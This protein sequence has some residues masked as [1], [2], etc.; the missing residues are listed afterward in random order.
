[1]TNPLII[2]LR[3]LLDKASSFEPKKRTLTAVFALY[4]ILLSAVSAFHEPWF[5]EAEAWQIAKCSSLYD[6]FFTVPHSEGHPPLWHLLLAPFAKAGM[7]YEFSL[8][9]VNIIFISA[10]VW[11]LMFRT[12]LPGLMRLLVPFTYFFF[13][14]YGVVARPYS[15]MTLAVMLCAVFYG[16]K[17]QKP[18]RMVLALAL[19]CLSSAYGLAMAAGICV[20]WLIE[21]WNGKNVLVFIKDFVKTKAFFSLL[22]LLVFAVLILSEVFP[23]KNATAVSGMTN[24]KST[25]QTLLYTLFILPFDATVGSVLTADRLLFSPKMLAYAPLSAIAVT[26]L[27]LF[28]KKHRQRR[29]LFIPLVFMPILFAAIIFYAHYAGIITVL[30]IFWLNVCFDNSDIGEPPASLGKYDEILHYVFAASGCV[31]IFV[32]I[33]WTVLSA[34]ADIKYNYSPCREIAAYIKEN[35]LENGNIMSSWDTY[36]S[37]DG[38]RYNFNFS[39]EATVVLPYFDRNIFRNFNEGRND[40]AYSDHKYYSDAEEYNEALAYIQSLDVPEYIFGTLPPRHDDSLDFI[41]DNY[42]YTAADM[43][44][45]MIFKGNFVVGHTVVY[46]FEDIKNKGESYE[47]TD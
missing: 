9:F 39:A 32:Q 20:V 45:S 44:H 23:D 7:P 17:S 5:D 10:A 11:V 14:Q 8:S 21:E 34:A 31:F 13:Y 24:I 12:K 43:E 40:K 4:I 46:K 37:E 30:L 3:S 16:N 29:L 2:K 47:G 1:M 35:H 33:M 27:I 42:Y 18:V 28:G 25:F 6:L 36:E 22:G 15:V 26:I 19:L 41:F 38:T